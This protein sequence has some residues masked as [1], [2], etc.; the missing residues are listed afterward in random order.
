VAII[1]S[2]EFFQGMLAMIYCAVAFEAGFTQ[3]AFP[4]EGIELL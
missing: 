3:A 1:E 4:D 2:L